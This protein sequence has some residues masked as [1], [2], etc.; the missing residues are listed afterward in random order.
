MKGKLRLFSIITLLSIS[1]SSQ[2]K[3]AMSFS[4]IGEQT[5]ASDPGIKF[6]V[7]Y[8][9]WDHKIGDYTSELVS[10]DQGYSISMVDIDIDLKKVK[11]SLKKPNIDCQGGFLKEL[12]SLGG[13]IYYFE[14]NDG[15]CGGVEPYILKGYCVR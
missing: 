2:A 15:D 3:E 9:D 5:Y 4:C 7:E 11:E 13:G 10:A 1:L 6:T 14:V 8:S 12:E